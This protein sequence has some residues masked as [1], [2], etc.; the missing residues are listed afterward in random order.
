MRLSGWSGAQLVKRILTRVGWIVLL[1]L[2]V[3]VY[4]IAVTRVDFM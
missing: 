3:V 2:I 4:I 1:A